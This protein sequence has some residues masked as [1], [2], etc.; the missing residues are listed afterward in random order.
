MITK[1][2][3]LFFVI[4]LGFFY[5]CDNIKNRPKHTYELPSDIK[6]EAQYFSFNQDTSFRIIGKEGTE[7]LIP[8]NSFV[9]LDET[10]IVGNVQFELK[11]FYNA[12]DIILNDLSTTTDEN[13]PLETGG[14][15]YISVK[16]GDDTL[17]LKTGNKIEIKFAKKGEMLNEM[18]LYESTKREN[19]KVIWNSNPISDSTNI[20]KKDTV[21]FYGE[22]DDS[23]SYELLK[24]D[25]YLFETSKLGWL[26]CDRPIK[27]SRKTE[28][29]VNC[30]DDVVPN[31]RIVFNNLKVVSFPLSPRINE[32]Q[33]NFKG[34]PLAA[35]ATIFAFYKSESKYYLF[36]KSIV[37]EENMQLDTEFKEVTL[38]NLKQEAL[39]LEWPIPKV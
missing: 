13:T 22:S 32:K 3:L 4:S 6:K 36:K 30:K 38:E 21:E 14:M 10:R 18:M 20:Y 28:L 8:A 25:Y 5:S 34:L 24:L 15:I 23:V 27:G 33:F 9:H 26:N 29:I 17:K 7:I 2:I 39:N 19:N 1:I 11:E 35:E 12:S 16:Q 31:I 37:L